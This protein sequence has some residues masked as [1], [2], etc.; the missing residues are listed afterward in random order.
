[1]TPSTIEVEGRVR[2][3]DPGDASSNAPGTGAITIDVANDALLRIDPSLHPAPG[4]TA[5]VRLPDAQTVAVRDAI[6]PLGMAFA[7]ARHTP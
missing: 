3:I 2:G 4:A 5:E 6:K 1:A 7:R